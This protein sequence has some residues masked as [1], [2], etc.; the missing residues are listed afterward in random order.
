LEEKVARNPLQH[1]GASAGSSPQEA[2]SPG[3]TIRTTIERGD[4]YLSPQLYNVEISLLEFVRGSAADERVNSQGISDK[5]PSIGFEYVLTRVR[6][7]YFRRARGLEDEQYILT[8]GQIA[9][10]SSDDM[11][12]YKLPSILQ[13]PQPQ[14]IGVVFNPGDSRE[15]WI[16]LQVPESDKKPLLIYKRKHVEGIYGIWGGIWFR[17]Y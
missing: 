12:E 5:P 8:E 14:L 16:L 3:T 9:A 7:G 17:L 6:L 15:G 4:A 10:V 1:Q 13:Q 2:A 11:T